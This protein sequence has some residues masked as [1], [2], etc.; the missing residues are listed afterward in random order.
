ML[1]IEPVNHRALA[2]ARKIHAV[3]MLAY[4][5][6]AALLEVRHFAPLDR[7]VE[8]LM[9]SD[10]YFLGAMD[11]EEWIGA[12]SLGADEEPNQ[13][14]ISALVIHPRYQRRGVGSLLVHE[15]LSRGSG[16]S[17][18]VST[19][20]KNA[21]ALA[22]YEKLGFVAYRYG[23]IGPEKLALVKLRKSAP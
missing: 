7:S 23:V 6:E 4:T 12:L 5:Q 18:S 22:L 10:D 16:M 13:L 14:N 17:F 8:D 9:A 20:Q 19:G 2:I 11:S 3:L 1:R 15:V 21:P